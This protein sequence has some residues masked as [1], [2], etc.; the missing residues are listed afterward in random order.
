MEVL[1]GQWGQE[2]LRCLGAGRGWCD[3]RRERIALGFLVLRMCAQRRARLAQ[4][5][6]SFPFLKRWQQRTALVCGP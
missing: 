2:E 4:R 5:R 1:A 3:S 6:D